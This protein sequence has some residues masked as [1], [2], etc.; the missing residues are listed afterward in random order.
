MLEKDESMVTTEELV[1]P[2]SFSSLKSSNEISAPEEVPDPKSCKMD[3]PKTDTAY[4]IPRL[5]ETVDDNTNKGY[6]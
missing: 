2:S 4:Y 6:V 1:T 5:G 3:I